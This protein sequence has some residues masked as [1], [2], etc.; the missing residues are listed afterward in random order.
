VHTKINGLFDA[1]CL[2]LGLSHA[3]DHVSDHQDAQVVTFLLGVTIGNKR[4]LFQ[5]GRNHAQQSLA[6]ILIESD[7]H[8]CVDQ[9][10][11]P[12]Y[13]RE[14]LVQHK[15]HVIRVLGNVETGRIGLEGALLRSAGG[16]GWGW[17]CVGRRRRRRGC[18]AAVAVITLAASDAVD[19]GDRGVKHLLEFPD[20]LVQSLHLIRDSGLVF[21]NATEHEIEI[22]EP[23]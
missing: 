11:Q 20:D 7:G 19:V 3:T 8:G 13:I 9:M 6:L 15:G 2:R 22:I 18:A 1:I 5:C 10:L 17:A 23:G 14:D 16:C 4:H 21:S 12:L